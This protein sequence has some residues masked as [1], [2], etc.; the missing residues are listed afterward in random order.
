MWKLYALRSGVGLGTV[1]FLYVMFGMNVGYQSIYR[2][3]EEVWSSDIVQEKFVL[4][5]SEM[6]TLFSGSIEKAKEQQSKLAKKSRSSVN[7]LEVITDDD[8]K[9]LDKLITNAS[10]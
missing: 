9:A 7:R 4:F 1:V 5:E 10:R 2:H 8:R 6:K 3:A